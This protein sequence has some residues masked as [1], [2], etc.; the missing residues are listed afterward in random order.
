VQIGNEVF[1]NDTP[2]GNGSIALSDAIK[3][4]SDTYF[5]T[6]GDSFWQ[7]WQAGDFVRGL[8]LQQEAKDF[9]FGSPTGIELS[10]GK[11]RIP[12]PQW[13]HDFAYAYYKTAT[14]KQQNAIWYPGDEVHLAVGQGDVLVTP[15]QLADAYAAFA[16]RGT[17]VTP[18]VGQKV[19]DPV[20]KKFVEQVD[21]KPRAQLSF[22]P[23]TYD[24]M[25]QGF[26]NVTADPK[27]TAYA[28]FQGFPLGLVPVA[29]K[30]G[31]AQVAG[32]A[33]TSVFAAFF[34]ANNPQYVVVAMVEQGGHGAQT[35]AP[36]VRRIIDSIINPLSVIQPNTPIAPV[37]TGK[38]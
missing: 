21:P 9:G 35:A 19:Y 5:Y 17:L 32:K 31:T 6:V 28:A 34:P 14:D 36:I 20:K 18:H 24:Q 37:G 8:G 1:S 25:L 33:P 11:G 22:D 2:G 23:A 16:N 13:K 30:T 15:L 38:D 27:G 29:G 7:T 3:V 4:S 10:E 26:E 12:D